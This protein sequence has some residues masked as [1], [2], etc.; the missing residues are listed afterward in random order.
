MPELELIVTQ[1][2][3]STFLEEVARYDV[4]SGIRLNTVMP[5]VEGTLVQT[6]ARLRAAIWPKTL[7]V[8]LKA[9][10]LRIREYANT[11]YTAVTISHAIKVKLPTTVYFDNGTLTAKL[12]AI[13]GNKLIFEGYVGRMLG[14]G[15]SVNILD[16][17][18]EYLQPKLL[19]PTDLAFV[20]A[21]REVDVP[22]LMLSYAESAEDIATVRG[23][24]P[25]AVILAKVE[26]KRGLQQIEALAA[27]AD[28][29]MA[30]RGDLYTEVDYPHQIGDALR[31]IVAASKGSAFVAS[32]MLESLL[33]HPLPSCPD[34]MDLLLLQE[35]GYRR[36]MIGDDLCF[37]RET[38]LQAIRVLLAVFGAAGKP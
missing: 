5:I 35:M 36:V 30:A 33:R 8:D 32:R 25:E 14:P 17:T 20:A 6:L 11:P 23:L 3:Y 15:E 37:K 2:P 16:D 18:L 19:T 10:Q 22:H 1:G 27:S 21:C 24:Y 28:A 12:V 31:R 7:W 38:L 4:V 26:S 13:D 34:I 9:R 29:V